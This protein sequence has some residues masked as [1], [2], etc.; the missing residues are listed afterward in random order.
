VRLA[1]QPAEP[2][3][4]PVAAKPANAAAQPVGSRSKSA[5]QSADVSLSATD[6]AASGQAKVKSRKVARTE[7]AHSTKRIARDD[8]RYGARTASNQQDDYYYGQRQ[9]Y[10]QQQGF[11][12]RPAAY[13]PAY[14]YA[15][16][17]SFGPFG[18]GSGRGW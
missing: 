9:R 13:A 18:A 2:E 8:A 15:P 10:A 17:P 11:G 14:A 1:S 16:Q 3:A 6:T 7:K 5:Q 12:Q 4:K